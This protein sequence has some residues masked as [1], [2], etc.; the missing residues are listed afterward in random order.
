MLGV[1]KFGPL[2]LWAVLGV[3]RGQLVPDRFGDAIPQ[4]HQRCARYTIVD[5]PAVFLQ[6][7]NRSIVLL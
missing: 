7:A 1:I 6:F 5:C 2:V 3:C 4:T